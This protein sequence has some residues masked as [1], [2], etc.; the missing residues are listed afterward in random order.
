[1]LPLLFEALQTDA[2][3][4]IE[5]EYW[6]AYTISPGATGGT[7]AL[8]AVI[9]GNTLYVA[10]TGETAGSS[11]IPPALFTVELHRNILAASKCSF[12]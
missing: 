10:N 11:D 5:R 8:V 7:T 2:V 9:W 3:L 4:Q 1:M 6:E 12:L